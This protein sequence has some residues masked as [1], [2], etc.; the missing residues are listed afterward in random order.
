ML[1][2]RAGTVKRHLE[3]IY[4]KLG[5]ANRQDALSRMRRPDL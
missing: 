1:E 5:A 2:L 3:N 4:R